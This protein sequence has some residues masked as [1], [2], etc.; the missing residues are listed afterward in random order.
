MKI[1]SITF[2]L[3]PGR[4]LDEQAISKVGAAAS[5]AVTNFQQAGYEVQT[6]RLATP[7]F[8][9]LFAQ[10]DEQDMIEAIQKL[11]HAAA[12]SG[13]AYIAVGPALLDGPDRYAIIPKII[14]NTEIIF[15]S[16]QMAT[17]QHGLSLPAVHACA[18]IIHDLALQDPD[19][20]ANLY[21]TALANVEAGSPFFPA[22]YHGGGSSGFSLATEA[23]SLA[24][25]AFE[26]PGSV[27]EGLNRFQKLLQ[28]HAG[29]LQKTAEHLQSETGF[30]F[31]GIDF[32]LA[33]FPE[34]DS[35]LGSA[36]ER[37]GIGKIGDHGSL[38]A[39]AMLA[40][41]LDQV[42][43]PKVGFSGLMFA[44]LEDAALA[45]RAAE[46]ALLV[47]DLLMYSAVCGTGLDTIPLPGETTPDQ[48]TPLLLDLAALALRLDKP[49]TARLMP[50]P[51]KRAG[52][53]TSFDFPFFANSRV[54]SLSAEPLNAPLNTSLSIPVFSRPQPK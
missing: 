32:S 26:E 4:P 8:P 15:C 3:D 52:E 51:G 36:V 25:D 23:A 53:E 29:R 37:M 21:F 16:A 35:S 43:F 50:I 13:F 39:A 5:R 2:F 42:S 12:E 46:G 34:D 31:N 10:L 33:P 27:T 17:K 40:S 30:K 44:Q 22:S 47:K 24:V 7:P 19:G 45:Q 9:R 28:F 11:E 20:F 49:L 48:L 54:M 18:Q 14:A 41:T 6:T 1:R 38:A